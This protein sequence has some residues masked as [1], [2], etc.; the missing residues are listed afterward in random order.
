MPGNSRSLAIVPA[1][2]G[3]KG[4]PNKN[5]RLFLGRP[6]IEWTIMTALDSKQCDRVVVST[7]NHVISSISLA[8]GAEVPFIRPSEYAKDTTSTV[9][10]VRHTVDWLEDNE[11]YVPDNILV[12]EPTSPGRRSEHIQ[13]AIEILVSDRTDSVASVVEVPHHFSPAKQLRLIENS[14]IVGISGLWPEQMVH[15]RQDLPITNA[16]DGT[17]FSC[18][19]DVIKQTPPTIWGNVTKGFVVDSRY[20]VD[21]D[22]LDDWIPS[23][24]KLRQVL[25]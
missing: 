12:L 6:L 19:Y 5:R 22:A 23:E 16:F 20:S 14:R 10:V 15:R 13:Q 18:K 3:S 25:I 7:D 8:C 4:I 1:R 24:E 21:L 9:A 17:I 11:Q 2:G